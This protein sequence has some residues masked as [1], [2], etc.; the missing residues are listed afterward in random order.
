M[1]SLKVISCIYFKKLSL[2]M[3]HVIFN[4]LTRHH[5]LIPINLIMISSIKMVKLLNFVSF[6]V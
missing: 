1:C 4:L 3:N 2:L 5:D 6:L